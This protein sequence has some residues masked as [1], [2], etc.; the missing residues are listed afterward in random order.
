M[1]RGPL[2]GRCVG[3]LGL[4]LVLLACGGPGS[5]ELDHYDPAE[6]QMLREQGRESGLEVTD[7]IL[8]E[9]LRARDDCRTI[10]TAL[11][12]VGKGARSGP[13]FDGLDELSRLNKERGQPE[14]ADYFKQLADKVRLGDAQEAQE[15]HAANCAGVK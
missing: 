7:D 12:A 11:D 15:Y 1:R 8:L 2:L 10:K 6:V 13:A 5:D 4:A 14:Q 3:A 9:T